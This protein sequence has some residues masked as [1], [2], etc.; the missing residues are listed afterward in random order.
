MVAVD[1]TMTYQ[2][3]NPQYLRMYTFHVFLASGMF[4]Y[5]LPSSLEGSPDKADPD[6]SNVLT[7]VMVIL[8][9]MLRLKFNYVTA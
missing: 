6:K 8:T 5:C 4:Q 9:P 7:L 1:T 3:S 2:R